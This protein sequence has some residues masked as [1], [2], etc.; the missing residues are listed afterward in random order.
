MSREAV[1]SCG[2][3]LTLIGKRF[4]QCVLRDMSAYVRL[5]QRLAEQERELAGLR[6]TSGR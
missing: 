3:G 4:I 1:G 5:E 2:A 6:G